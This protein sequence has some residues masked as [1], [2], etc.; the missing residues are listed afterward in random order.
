LALVVLRPFPA[1][2]PLGYAQ[3]Y[4]LLSFASGQPE[5]LIDSAKRAPAEIAAKAISALN[6]L[7]LDRF[8]IFFA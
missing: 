3:Q 1:T 7:V 5:P 2:T 8:F 4:E 6:I